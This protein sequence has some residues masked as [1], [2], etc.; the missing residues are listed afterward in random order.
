M[1]LMHALSLNREDDT[2]ANLD[3]LQGSMPMTSNFFS[4]NQH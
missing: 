1:R 3:G 2:M 4:V